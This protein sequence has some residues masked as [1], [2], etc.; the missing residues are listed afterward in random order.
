MVEFNCF[1]KSVF[2]SYKWG[3][4]GGAYTW[5]SEWETEEQ[6]QSSEYGNRFRDFLVCFAVMIP[7][8]S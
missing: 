1:A 3:Y 2:T 8:F 7:T 5:P 6:Q 4:G